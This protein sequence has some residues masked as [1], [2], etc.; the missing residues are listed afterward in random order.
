[1]SKFC[2]LHTHSYFSDG[3]LSPSELIDEAI[4]RG[5]CAVALCDHNTTAGL[6][7]F[8]SAAERK[9]IKAIP[10]IEISSVYNGT[11]LHILG[12][13]LPR[14]KYGEVEAFLE[15][16]NERKN[17]A[18]KLL[19]KNLNADGY[20]ISLEDIRATTPDGH[21]NRAHIAQALAAAGYVKDSKEAFATLLSPKGKHYVEPERHT[22]FEVIDFL[23]SIGAVTVLAHPLLSMGIAKTEKFLSEASSHPL[24]GM[25]TV[26][27]TYTEKESAKAKELA[28]KFGLRES[29]GSD[30]HG[31]RKPGLML[32]IGYG[33]LKIPLEFAEKLSLPLDG[34]VAT[35]LTDE[36]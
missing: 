29:G 26:Y 17:A 10:G 12:L 14:D 20:M 13:F 16:V 3:T 2:D 8:L 25:E 1:M 31:E 33:D 34:K 32:G 35:K 9:D 24:D 5:L 15:I 19:E 23:H 21:I 18:Y 28:K 11:E 27:C 30:F 4:K 6:D 36:V 22:S 7:E